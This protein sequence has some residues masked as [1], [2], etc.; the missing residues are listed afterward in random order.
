MLRAD[1]VSGTGMVGSGDKYTI[2]AA[3]VTTN[4]KAAPGRIVRI[5]PLT[6]TG[7]VQVHDNALGDTSGNQVWPAVAQVLSAA[8]IVVLDVPMTTGI[9]VTV[10]A[11]TTCLVVYI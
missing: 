7:T 6:G 2:C 11:T 10:G 8:G 3:G 4:V 1:Q 9:A 5:I